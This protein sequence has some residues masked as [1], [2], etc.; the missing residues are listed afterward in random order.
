MLVYLIFYTLLA[1]LISFIFKNKKLGY[2]F[3]KL[4]KNLLF[5][6]LKTDGENPYHDDI[7]NIEIKFIYGCTYSLEDSNTSNQSENKSDNTINLPDNH[8]P[9]ETNDDENTN[10]TDNHEPIETNDDENTNLTDNHE[11]IETSFENI[12]ENNNLTDNHEPIETSFENIDENNNLTDNEEV[13]YMNINFKN[14]S[15]EKN[16]NKFKKFIIDRIPFDGKLYFIGFNEELKFIVNYLNKIELYSNDIE[17][18]NNHAFAQKTIKPYK[19]D[20][21]S[22]WGHENPD[23]LYSLDNLTSYL[24]IQSDIANVETQYELYK[25]LCEKNNLD[26]F[27]V[28]KVIR[29]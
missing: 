6:K 8:E 22:W 21:S 24:N 23:S 9:I 16:N 5:I 25:T 17:F 14:K 19:R 10:L 20:S 28:E 15:V 26:I 1:L 2:D 29:Y 11:P 3:E 12:D 4:D 13:E 18:I 27:D 7:S